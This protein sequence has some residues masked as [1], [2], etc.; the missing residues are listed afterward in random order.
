MSRLRNKWDGKTM[1]RKYGIFWGCM[2]PALQPFVEKATRIAFRNLQIDLQEMPE[3]TCCPDPEI[4][5]T[6][7]YD[8]WLTMAARNFSLAEDA[9]YDICTLCNGCYDTFSKAGMELKTHKKYRDMVNVM[10]QR[11]GR[12]YKGTVQSLHV[13]E[14]LHDHVGVDAI[15]KTV[16]RPLKNIAV[17][18]QYGCRIFREDEKQFPMKFDALVKALGATIAEYGSEKLCCGVPIM[19]ADPDYALQK[20]A[21]VKL[22][23]IKVSRADCIVVVCPACFDRIERAQKTLETEGQEYNIP[24]FHYVE[25]L[26]LAQGVDPD[27]FG[28]SFHRVPPDDFLQKIGG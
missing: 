4:T 22:I 12:T 27:K 21:K 13:V 16:S 24:V 28:V 20:R 17:A 6:L 18:M 26:A 2:I 7:S 5:R 9:G 3:A 10:L 25:L 8:F 15:K 11:V 23:D 1:D 14:I 19:Y